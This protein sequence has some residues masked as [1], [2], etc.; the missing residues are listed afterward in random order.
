MV[1]IIPILTYGET[2]TAVCDLHSAL[3]SLGFKI[4]PKEQG[5][6][7]FGDTTRLAVNQFQ[8]AQKLNA[9]GTVDEKT[10][11]L[12]NDQLAKC[13]PPL[14]P[15]P[16]PSKSNYQ[17]TG[18][19]RDKTGQ[20]VSGVGV[21]V[22]EILLGNQRNLLAQSQTDV[23]GYYNINYY[24][25]DD[26]GKFAI[27]VV[28]LD[29]SG[30]EWMTSP[31]IF[32]AQ[33]TEQVDFMEGGGKYN[34]PSEYT[35]R[36]AVLAPLIGK[37]DFI[38]LVENDKQ[39]DISFLVGQSGF[40]AQEVMQIVI[41]YH[42]QK[43]TSIDPEVF[44]GLFRQHLPSNLPDSL[45][46]QTYNFT[47]V[48]SLVNQ[49]L[50]GI[51]ALN[52]TTIKNAL[53][54]AV[55][56]NTVSLWISIQI[57]DIMSKF[58]ALRI[59]QTLNSPTALGK[60]SL[61]SLLKLTPLKEET[62]TNFATIFTQNQGLTTNFWQALEKNENFDAATIQAVKF[63]LTAGSL[64]KYQLP[65][66]S[67]LIKQYQNKSFNNI[68]DLA[69][70]DET[71]WI[72]VIQASTT[73][74]VKGYPSNLD[75]KTEQDKI[76]AYAQILTTNFQKAFPT[77]ALAGYI[78][79]STLS[80]KNE[81]VSF[82]D[83]NPQ[84]DLRKVNLT[85]LLNNQTSSSGNDNS[86]TLKGVSLSP[87]TISNLKTLQ[88][89]LQIAPSANVAINLFEQGIRSAQHVYSM[90]KTRLI[91][92]LSTL[93]IATTD[94]ERT[95]LNAEAKYVTMLAQLQK[96][97]S[98]FNKVIPRVITPVI[99]PDDENLPN[100]QA[101][102]GSLDY[103]AC[104]DCQS[105][106]SPQAYFTDILHFLAG[107]NSNVPDPNSKII[108]P[109]LLP[110][111][112]I[113]FE[114][115]PD[116]GEI[117]LSCANSTTSLPYI[118][119]VNE[120]LEDAIAPLDAYTLDPTTVS[121]LMQSASGTIQDNLLKALNGILP[122]NI[123]LS[124]AAVV[125][126]I[127]K[128][129]QIWSIQD[130]LQ[131][132]R[133]NVD[134]K[135]ASN[136]IIKLSRQS[137]AS[138]DELAAQ[139][140]FV[141]RA[142]Y[143]HILINANYPTTLPFDLDWEESRLYLNNIG[144]K[145]DELLKTF[146]SPNVPLASDKVLLI[147]SEF[148]G[149]SQEE[150][151]II[152]TVNPNK[153]NTYWGIEAP[154]DPV[155]ALKQVSAFL[156]Q[157]GFT[158]DNNEGY[159]NLLD[160]LACTF[161][162][163]NLDNQVNIVNNSQGLPE[164]Q[165]S[166]IQYA[167]TSDNMVDCSTKTQT[168]SSL[169]LP[170]LDR[171]HRF[172]RLWRK[173]EWQMWELDLLLCTPQVG[174]NLLDDNA[175][176]NL[177]YF[178]KL[179]THLNLSTE[180]LLA[181]FGNI[182]AQS[183]E[184]NG[185]TNESLY[186]KLF[187]NATITQS[188][189]TTSTTVNAPSSI[190][191]S[192]AFAVSQVENPNPIVAL[193]CVA[194]Q[195]QAALNISQSDFLLLLNT[196][197]QIP[198]S[199]FLSLSNLSEL[200]RYSKLSQ[201]LNLSITN[202][203]VLE[204][205]I[206]GDSPFTN[207]TALQTFLDN[208]QTL[209]TSPLSIAELSYLLTPGYS[210]VGLTQDL[211]DQDVEQIRT[212]L[213]KVYDSVY[214]SGTTNE[215]SLIKNLSP[216]FQQSATVQQ[217]SA[218][219]QQTI[220]K[221]VE[222]TLVATNS[223]AS[224]YFGGFVDSADIDDLVTNLNSSSASVES[225]CNHIF[226][227]MYQYYATNTIAN[228]VSGLF[229]IDAATAMTAVTMNS[230]NFST[231]PLYT[232]FNDPT[233][234]TKNA[235]ANPPKSQNVYVNPIN[236]DQENII[237]LLHKISFLISKYKITNDTFTWLIN[238]SNQ[239]TNYQYGKKIAGA[240]VAGLDFSKLPPS[241]SD[242][243]PSTP[244]TSSVSSLPFNS[245][246]FYSWLALHQ[247][248]SFYNF[249][250]VNA[251]VSIL[252][253]I[254]DF[255]DPTQ[256][257]RTVTNLIKDLSTWTTWNI[258]DVTSLN[259][260]LNFQYP[261][262]YRLIDTYL[263][264]AACF[265]F[266][267]RAGV[268]ISTLLNWLT[269]SIT[270]NQSN[271]IIQTVKSR[272]SSDQWIS[273]STSL[274][275]TLRDKKRDALVS[276]L[277]ANPKG[278]F[279]NPAWTDSNGLYAYFLI[280]VEMC[281]CQL[282]SRI[283][284]ASASVQLFV[285]RCFLNLEPDVQVQVSDDEWLQ[286]DWMKNYR[287]WEANRQVFLYP[288]NWIVPELRDNKTL[289]FENFENALQ[290]NEITN[291]NVENL[292]QNY[293]ESLDIVSRLEVCGLCRQEAQT[294]ANG[295]PI[296]GEQ[297]IE[298]VIARTKSS[299]HSY[300]YRRRMVNDDYWTA[301]EEVKLDIATEQVTPAFYNRKLYL[302][303]P[304][305]TEK[306]SR[307][308]PSPTA[309]NIEA[310]T[311]PPDAKKYLEIQIAWS[312]YRGGAW[313]H[314]TVSK[315]K[316]IDPFSRPT[317]SYSFT[318]NIDPD[319]NLLIN[320]F[321]STSEEFNDALNVDANGDPIPD[322]Y[323]YLPLP[324]Y[325]EKKLPWHFATF[326]FD[327]HVNEVSL[328][329]EVEDP[330]GDAE[331][332]TTTTRSITYSGT[333]STLPPS[334]TN[335]T[336][337]YNGQI[338][339]ITE[340]Y[341]Y[342]ASNSSPPTYNIN[343]TDNIITYTY[344][345]LYDF[346]S[347]N[348]GLDGKSIFP[349]DSSTYPTVMSTRILPLSGYYQNNFLTNSA[350]NFSYLGSTSSQITVLAVSN[351]TV[352]MGQSDEILTFKYEPFEVVHDPSVS[353]QVDQVPS[354]FFQD[355]TRNF[356]VTL[357]QYNTQ[358]SIINTLVPAGSYT[359]YDFYHPY[360]TLF[361]HELNRL[362]I[363][364]LLNNNIQNSPPITPTFNNPQYSF[365]GTYNPAQYTTAYNSVNQYTAPHGEVVDFGQNM[366][367]GP[368]NWELFFHLPFY[369]AS[370]LYQNQRFEEAK[371]WF[372]YIFNPSS[373]DVIQPTSSQPNSDLTA[374]Y[375]ITQPFRLENQQDYT[376]QQISKLL[377]GASTDPDAMNQIAQWR[378]DPFN[379]H[380]IARLR[381][382]AYQWA[383]VMK[384][385]DNLIAWGDQLFAQNTLESINEATQLYIMASNIL[386]PKPI[387]SPGPATNNVYKTYNEIESSLDNFSNA[388]EDYEN[389]VPLP[390]HIVFDSGFRKKFPT[391]LQMFYFCIPANDK[392]LGYW[393]LV[394]DRLFKIRHCMN[395][396]GI[397]QQLPLFSPPIDPSLL[398]QAKAAGLDISAILGLTNAPLPNYRFSVMFRKA[399]ELCNEVKSLG[400]ALLSALEK[401]DGEALALLRASNELAV[402]KDMEQI[403]Q[404]QLD[405]ATQQV[406][407]LQK[408]SDIANIRSTYYGGLLSTGL[409]A[410]ETT[411]LGLTQSSI[412]LDQIIKIGNMLAGEVRLIPDFVAGASGAG[413]SPVVTVQAGGAMVAGAAE[414]ILNAMAADSRSFEK[415][416]S[417]SS[418]NATYQRRVQEWTNQ[419]NLANAEI[420]QI[421][422]QIT[423]ANIRVQIAND[424]LE[425]QQ[426]QTQN[427]QSVYDYMSSKFTNEDLYD[428]MVS[429]ISAT[430][431][432]AYQLAYDIARQAEK[433]YQFETGQYST[434]II[435]FGYWNSLKK[436]LLAAEQ[437]SLD[438]NRLETTYLTQNKREYEITKQ[439]SLAQFFPDILVMLKSTG[440]CHLDL[441]EWLFDLDYPG[442][443]MRR[444]KAVSISIPCVVGPYTSVNCTLTLVKNS[445]RITNDASGAYIS[446]PTNPTAGLK[447]DLAAVQS[448]IV[449]SHARNDNGMF[450]FNFHDDRY[451]P[452]EG[453]G[454]ISS[455]QIDLPQDS[456]FF[457]F[458]SI[459]DV[460]ITIHYTSR[461]GG[462]ILQKAAKG[463][464]DNYLPSNGAQFFDVRRD[465]STE[466]YRFLHPDTSGADQELTILF[467]QSHFPF[468]VRGKAITITGLKI[469][470]DINA[471]DSGP[472]SIV[473]TP[474]G[475]N[476]ISPSS[477]LVVNS[478][479][480]N[481]HCLSL[482]FTQSPYIPYNSGQWSFKI[483]KSGSTNFTSL[484][485]DEIRNI[486]F[487]ISFT[488]P[489][490]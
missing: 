9:T 200:Y 219:D 35:Q 156:N 98:N 329:N 379:P 73:A 262:D 205:L 317:Y 437:L 82:F 174:N 405:E 344:D 304:V 421:A 288:E 350:I 325:D 347:N 432:Q 371:Q 122:S 265:S 486:Y 247:L 476:P 130:Y 411:A 388:L 470:A 403:K 136:L 363:P 211:I 107:R 447:N 229:K 285:Q 425:N 25:S 99:L 224:Q 378:A 343:Y 390:H 408:S 139:P 104:N 115:R 113:L 212:D 297:P 209:K 166:T 291:D 74:D 385:L 436:G 434:Q 333:S 293:L 391:I 218:T 318:I 420:T 33:K 61:T 456:N 135:N 335:V 357:P 137:L 451:L 313:S 94:I 328:L 21:E 457:D 215:D 190:L 12:I 274:Q 465:F 238:N 490:A 301:W 236:S 266:A 433:T 462:G 261:D 259:N 307:N 182:N 201:T 359:F 381:P 54:S 150:L 483:Q 444:I 252:S 475:V 278:G 109:H 299:P 400:A 64:T 51:I 331:S 340:T 275:N 70:W 463:Y 487:V 105:V 256:K 430:Y 180:E 216:F 40:T 151:G 123:Q 48:D 162:S 177:Y 484:Q 114:R 108:P 469:F 13:P 65:L 311:P 413:G 387:Q 17:V 194:T 453:A 382:V 62:Y 270:T 365:E 300:Y 289:F 132:Y 244:S 223:L 133:I 222:G 26:A 308:Q 392:L 404:Q 341:T 38:D 332:F 27:S 85:T 42:L 172:I 345:S 231:G 206:G 18:T 292:F 389:S 263:C 419:Q 424:E 466:W 134:P 489:E 245:L 87:E 459:S 246:N 464:I 37:K 448:S 227:Y 233:W 402:L 326:V 295:Q 184:Q 324:R 414:I 220:I 90:G 352:S 230:S 58:D 362:G 460:I 117:E 31:T 169:S 320:T 116:L 88:R 221:M 178:R 294:D 367:Y 144:I 102:F 397:V 120:I 155:S 204:N 253:I 83:N 76:N 165:H 197:P 426:L 348:Y 240:F 217:L 269:T 128:T 63:T 372:E 368:Y 111:K 322:S 154:N 296:P 43:Q 380:L 202:L 271:Q 446:D 142:A 226:A 250:P 441:P 440:M 260:S 148:F 196:F 198:S 283:V 234:L 207:L 375:W 281:P 60:T 187:L 175:L 239:P 312:Y 167:S 471:T 140:E 427:S 267:N 28:V 7:C 129:E 110:A 287:V 6:N 428:W 86:E 67:T 479:Y 101:L 20:T 153:Q 330:N 46:A 195:I 417:V 77:D 410:P 416:S 213:Q 351:P 290:Q 461:D 186:E 276:Y 30:K 93:G 72:K 160:L 302:F 173:T 450:E 232:Y 243:P 176:I 337:K 435:Q 127:D 10:A 395:I 145:R 95:Y 157:A 354:F 81:I 286:W 254:G 3:I 412:Q 339:S 409:I 24:K 168:I 75:G 214:N 482:D 147:A 181:F 323:K 19:V 366:A 279:I 163:F 474:P 353:F 171:M 305:F 79:R 78:Q 374:K 192:A 143:D 22:Y 248:L 203:L 384:Y 321:I 481:L 29:K 346:V 485:P 468:Y 47:M 188:S 183:W 327:G 349:F 273:I 199:Q 68:N 393:D 418:V 377:A 158:P 39:K 210:T 439:I 355:K 96:Y 14:K 282:T 356:Y 36:L 16:P 41:S 106:Y 164:I 23:N 34:G 338:I 449:T 336:L 264:L 89:N 364:G 429:Q 383:V 415:Q 480:G 258:D 455:W 306:T 124:D 386:G 15:T 237:V 112:D 141:N 131:Y 284:Q 193:S 314:K 1:K 477:Q 69:R 316:I 309:S 458:N 161:V 8:L 473:F 49:L 179:Q 472:Y 103:C 257:S 361:I 84:M 280:D 431:F 208:Y 334:S 406:D 358:S 242:V 2:G 488:I 11:E 53:L 56:S 159:N 100:L 119:L 241:S 66:V 376:N 319:D 370:S 423:A 125:T 315:S 45:L 268:K 396:E 401:K 303:W 369:I 5:K 478:T 118:D 80:N 407:A 121:Y 71:Q 394:A 170:Q 97:N 152:T 298:H 189:T 138:A 255:N 50:Q 373:T 52:D 422:S 4:D 452:F 310:N 249:Y 228:T 146:Y 438:L 399:K 55:Q 398:I 342:S 126:V 251:G 92:T 277:V 442:H 454:A 360:T 44:Y 235:P 185:Q 467:D 59:Q 32:Q 225:R 91:G 272:Y 191:I 445:L 57:N 443:Y 149:I